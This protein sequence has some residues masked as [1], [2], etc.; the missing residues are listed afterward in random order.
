MVQRI[1]LANGRGFALVDDADAELVSGHRWRIKVAPNTSYARATGPR[2]ARREI[3]M[4]TL[5]AGYAFTDHA[6]GDGLNN[7]RYNLR[8]ADWLRNAQNRGLQRR[9]GSSSYKGVC[10]HKTQGK[11]MAYIAHRHL[12]YFTDEIAAARAYDAAAHDLF[13]EYARPNFPATG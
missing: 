8:P 9:A 6:D 10:W 7:Q 1:P 2:P 13:G 11:W 12:G 3:G 4:H 5:I